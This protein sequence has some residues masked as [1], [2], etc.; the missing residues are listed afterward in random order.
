[1]I[2]INFEFLESSPSCFSNPCLNLAGLRLKEGDE[3]GVRGE[4]MS[5]VRIGNYP[6]ASGEGDG[7]GFTFK[8]IHILKR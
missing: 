2:C 8:C 5:M 6:E 1:M 4:D 3:V 7:V